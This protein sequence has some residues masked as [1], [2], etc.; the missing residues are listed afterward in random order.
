MEETMDVTTFSNMC[1]PKINVELSH[2]TGDRNN[3]HA[4]SGHVDG[5]CVVTVLDHRPDGSTNIWL[6][7]DTT[8]KIIKKD[9]I[10]LD[11]ISL[12]IAKIKDDTFCVSIIP[13]TFTNTTIQYWEINNSVNIEYN[14]ANY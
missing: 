13:H 6:K 7:Y 3:G 10:C 14:K 9:S 1:Y 8:N 4:V 2:R 12:T 5:V 11:G